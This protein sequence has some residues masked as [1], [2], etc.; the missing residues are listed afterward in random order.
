MPKEYDVPS[1]YRRLD[2]PVTSWL[3]TPKTPLTATA[4]ER[5]DAPFEGDAAREGALLGPDHRPE[6]RTNKAMRLQREQRRF[7]RLRAIPHYTEAPAYRLRRDQYQPQ[8]NDSLNNAVKRAE[9]YLQTWRAQ[10]AGI[11]PA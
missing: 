9:W 4:Q 1:E 7:A 6:Q 8:P 3:V 11:T 10:R 2:K 5:A